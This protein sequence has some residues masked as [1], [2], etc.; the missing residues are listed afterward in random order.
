MQVHSALTLEEIGAEQGGHGL[1]GH[2]ESHLH[3]DYYLFE[4]CATW[5]Q[6]LKFGR[7]FGGL[8]NR[9]IDLTDFSRLFLDLLVVEQQQQLPY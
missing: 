3:D 2:R 1:T 7:N 4:I 6:G 8:K 5:E 9:W